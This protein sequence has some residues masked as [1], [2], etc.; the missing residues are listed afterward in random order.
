MMPETRYLKDA[1][2]NSEVRSPYGILDKAF[3][4]GV[5]ACMRE[6][7]RSELVGRGG[8]GFPTARKWRMVQGADYVCLICNGDE[9]EPGTF[10]DRYIMENN[11]ALLLEGILIAGYTL[12]AS[13]IYVYIRGEYA[14]ALERMRSA[15][16]AADKA[17]HR[18]RQKTGK[19]L[20]VWIVKG[21][22]AYVCGDETSL[23]NSIEGRRPNSRIKPPYPTE[24]GLFGHP[25]VVN[26]V[27][28]LCN[29]PLIIRDSGQAFAARGV[30]GSRGTKLVCLSGCVQTPGV[31]EIEMGKVTL[32]QLIWELGGGIRDGHAFRFAIPGGISTQLLTECNLDTPLDYRSLREAGTAF[33]SGAVIV[34]DDTVSVVDTASNVADFYMKETCGICFP[35]KEGNRQIHHLLNKLNTG[36]GREEYLQLIC[37]ISRTTTRAARCGL[38]QS[39]G[40][41]IESTIAHFRQEYVACISAAS[42]K[43]ACK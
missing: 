11:P 37:D 4:M 36:H 34:A 1:I 33:G 26:N 38:G 20:K 39:A 16:E 43:E 17:L 31:Y 13:E 2:E 15:L 21:Q 5:E 18:Y 14:L 8:A 30:E 35:C 42:G 27:E 25:T 3:A 24:K 41:F 22:G 9:G 23:I 40:N 28:T 29:I 7:D 6:I 12:H 32:R 19:D 10:K